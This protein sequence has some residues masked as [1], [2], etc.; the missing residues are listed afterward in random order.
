MTA[1]RTRKKSAPTARTKKFTKNSSGK[2]IAYVL[3]IV[4]LVLTLGGYF[5]FANEKNS[6]SFLPTTKRKN[7]DSLIQDDERI[8]RNFQNG[9]QRA[10][11]KTSQENAQKRI[12]ETNGREKFN[13]PKYETKDKNYL[14]RLI[15]SR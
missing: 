5:Y 2:V 13:T 6:E 12:T 4:F 15:Q 7:D 1:V 14:D 11:Q 9:N 3:I 8:Y 10:E